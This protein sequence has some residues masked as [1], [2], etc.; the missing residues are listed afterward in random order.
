M[1]Y[2]IPDAYDLEGGVNQEK[3]FSVASQRYR[4]VIFLKIFLTVALE[5]R[6]VERCLLVLF[7]NLRSS[8]GLLLCFV[9]S[10]DPGAA[11]KMNPFAEQEAW[12]EHQIGNLHFILLKLFM[13][14]EVFESLNL[15]LSQHR[16]GDT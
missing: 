5:Y 14:L 8:Y 9:I 11:E 7:F 16:E 10:R 13:N 15:E 2:R 3:R 1:Q 12:E 6:V 4:L